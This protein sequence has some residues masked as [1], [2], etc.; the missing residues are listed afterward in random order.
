MY[1]V[2]IQGQKTQES[3]LRYRTIFAEPIR[4]R[5]IG[6]CKWIESGTTIDTALPELKSL[7][8]DK[9]EWRAVIVRYEDD[10]CMAAYE[11]DSA[12]P[13]DFAINQDSSDTVGENPVPLVRLTQMLGGV[14]PLEVKFRSEVIKEAHRA[15]RTVY[16]P[17]IDREK[18]EAH[19]EL[20]RKY[21]YNGKKP[22]ELLIITLRNR[23]F[24][25]GDSIGQAWLNHKESESSEFWKRNHFPSI[26]R[27]MVYDVEAKGSV[28]KEADD[29][30]F[31]Y[32]VMLM[33]CNSWD[34]STMQAYRLYKL[35]VLLDKPALEEAFQILAD[36][37][38]DAKRTIERSIKSEREKAVSEAEKLPDY[39]MNISVPFK[40]PKSEER[41]VEKKLFHIFSDGPASDI[42]LWSEQKKDTEE[43]VAKHVR[44]AERALNATAER[45]RGNCTFTEDEVS[46]LGKYQEEDLRKEIDG[47]Y[48][49]IMHI[50]SVL[51]EER[52]S[53]DEGA[54]KASVDVKRYLGGRVGKGPVAAVVLMA[55]MLLILASLPVIFRILSGESDSA[56]ALAFTLLGGILLIILFAA[57]MLLR[58]KARLDSLIENYN[59]YIRR[60]FS[61]LVGEVGTY[62]SYMSEI[63][64][65]IRG[66]SYL[67]LAMRKKQDQ[68]TE[69]SG[70]YQH[71]KAIQIFLGKLQSWSRAYH[72]NVDFASRRPNVK[73]NFDMSVPP[74]ENK[75]YIFETGESYPVAVNNSGMTMESPYRFGRKIEI[76]REE[77]YDDK[78]G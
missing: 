35:N 13:Y 24:F 58:Q 33:A 3:F 55:A 48:H 4:N 73:V 60:D 2:I 45:M 25:D 38:R 22:S 9:K 1:S 8:D 67:A 78:C 62:S 51:P 47:I 28:Q 65:H 63:A 30:S 37:L 17:I 12:N 18:E 19:R 10:D 77:I 52:L 44:E 26:C 40:L 41:L 50:Q 76:V 70:K 14:P 46:P 68:G 69:R 42:A 23:S 27:F 32:A 15:P 36:R 29:F 71:L 54:Q 53:S 56:A 61:Q 16:V 57:G 74:Q 72:L 75:L 6:I 34:P 66:A 21:A 7:T 11:A 64:S 31:W 59:H 5:Q 20:A 43:R 39:R 49:H